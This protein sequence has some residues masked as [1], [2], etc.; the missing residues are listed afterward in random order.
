MALFQFV[1]RAGAGIAA[2]LFIICGGMLTYEVIA[3]YFFTRPTIW[4]AELSQLC[5]IWGCMLAMP[6]ILAAGRHIQ[7][8]AVARLLPPATQRWLHV[9]VMVVIAVFSAVVVWYGF[10][11]FYDSFERGRTTGSM[12]DIPIWISELSI[13]VGFLLLMLQALIDMVGKLRGPVAAESAP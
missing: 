8:D 2:T 9:F 7:V 6:W 13:P 12:L 4:A 1:L 5:L 3:R 10:Q 11:I